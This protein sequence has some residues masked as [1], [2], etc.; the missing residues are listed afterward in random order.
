MYPHLFEEEISSG[1]YCDTLLAGIYNGDL[2][3][4]INDHKHVVITMLGRR[5]AI[6]IV[7]QDGFPRLD[8]SSKRGVQAILLNG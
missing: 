8:R 1:F 7:H 4:S 5:K 3:K 2:R 6:H